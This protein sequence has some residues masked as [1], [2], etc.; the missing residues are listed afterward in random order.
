MWIFH[1]GTMEQEGQIVTAGGRV[2]AVSAW[3]PDLSTAADRAYA[4]VSRI[5]F[6]GMQFRRD[7]GRPGWYH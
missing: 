2:L 3:G 4:A 5:H 6:E 1:A 7:I